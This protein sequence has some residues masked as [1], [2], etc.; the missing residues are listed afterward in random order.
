MGLCQ[1]Q[2]GWLEGTGGVRYRVGTADLNGD[3]G[4][5]ESPQRACAV[6]GSAIDQALMDFSA[7][8]GSGRERSSGASGGGGKGAG[9]E[10]RRLSL[11]ARHACRAVR[12]AR[13]RTARSGHPH[14]N[15]VGGPS[16]RARQ[17]GP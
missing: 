6:W 14:S 11:R 2:A 12:E 13:V 16:I 1:G 9:Q 17:R 15:A 3:V 10:L 7:K 8:K 4:D 5:S